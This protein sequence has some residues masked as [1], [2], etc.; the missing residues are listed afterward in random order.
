M[1]KTIETQERL[2]FKSLDDGIA[3][4]LERLQRFEKKYKT[5]S[6]QFHAD[7]RRGRRGLALDYERWASEYELY[8]DLVVRRAQEIGRGV[9]T[10]ST[11]KVSRQ[12]SLPTARR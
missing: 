6:E 5:K 1:M 8:L 2:T 3:E 10:K 11:R 4:L 7:Y 9:S 12:R